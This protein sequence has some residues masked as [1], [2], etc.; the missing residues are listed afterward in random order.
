[1]E[2]VSA[3]RI[4]WSVA[5]R[6]LADESGDQYLVARAPSAVMVAVVDGLGHGPAAAAAARR[7]VDLLKANAG[8]HPVSLLQHCH[9]ALRSTRGAVVSLASFDGG[10][11]TWLG[12]G[13]VD[14]VLVRAA[15]GAG[16]ERLLVRG[17][18]VGRQLPPLEAAQVAVGPGDVLIFATDG[19]RSDF[20]EDVSGRGSPQSTA[21]RILAEYGKPSDD[22]L[23]MV[24]RYLGV[25]E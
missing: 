13:N 14:G 6:S 9:E 17:G 19:V 11:M 20:A 1:M 7:A 23:V 21:D 5:L 18:V 4:D 16:T 12:V 10:S 22:A 2:A 25:D 8:A 24:A 3:P 15:P